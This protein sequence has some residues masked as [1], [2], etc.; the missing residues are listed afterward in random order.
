M[1]AVFGSFD[2]MLVLL[3]GLNGQQLAKVATVSRGFKRAAEQLRLDQLLVLD[4]QRACLIEPDFHTGVPNWLVFNGG[5]S[6][7]VGGNNSVREYKLPAWATGMAFS[8]DNSDLYIATYDSGI[9]QFD[10]RS[11]EHRGCTRLFHGHKLWDTIIYPEGLLCTKGAIC[12]AGVNSCCVAVFVKDSADTGLVVDLGGDDCVPW[13]LATGPDGAVYVSVERSYTGKKGFNV[14]DCKRN[15]ACQTYAKPPEDPRGAILRFDFEVEGE[16]VKLVGEGACLFAG[17]DGRLSRP[18][19]MAFDAAGA[20]FV[21]SLMHEIL[22]YAEPHHSCPGQFLRVFVDLEVIDRSLQPFD[23]HWRSLHN[24]CTLR[25]EEQL[26]VTA[27]CGAK[28]CC[29]KS[30]N[31]A[32]VKAAIILFDAVGHLVSTVKAEMGQHWQLQHP[33]T[34]AMRHQAALTNI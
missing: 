24:P 32:Q 3:R 20:L 23:V 28:S 26:I 30:S 13:N 7:T 9:Q 18:S 17:R 14:D 29:R 27:H 25:Q 33:N 10:G 19:G 16:E 1:E 6:R 15:A 21:T 11:F 31:R 5:H 8:E 12:C 34:I 22:Q 2:L 4:S